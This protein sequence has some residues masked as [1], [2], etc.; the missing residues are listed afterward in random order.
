[1]IKPRPVITSPR[2]LVFGAALLLP[3]AGHT[4]IVA[5]YDFDSGFASSD[6]DPL[7]SAGNFLS[8]A[9]GTFASEFGALAI[10]AGTSI[11]S[12]TA[13]WTARSVTNASAGSTWFDFAIDL[14]PGVSDISF[15]SLTF[16]AYVF[17][18]I[19]GT[20]AFNYQVSWDVD[21]FASPIGSATGPSITSA[22]NTAAEASLALSFDLS[23]LPAQ[24]TDINFRFDPVLAPGS[25]GN[26][27]VFPP[28][29]YQR[30]AAIDNLILNATVA[31]G[32]VPVPGTLLLLAI[33]GLGL[34]FA[35]K[36]P[37]K[38]QANR[39]QP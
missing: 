39:V 35:G 13:A 21:G 31:T 7:T 11:T 30:G 6:T 29:P 20:T 26:G 17:H 16:D 33:G 12:Q 36:R 37:G 22:L 24:T 38:R 3:V 5:Q 15:T 2:T 4:A 32:A 34:A 27:G 9:T 23:A 28:N 10:P 18:T 25:D 8:Q 1:M 14:D 19:G